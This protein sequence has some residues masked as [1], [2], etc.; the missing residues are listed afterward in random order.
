MLSRVSNEKPENEMR[1]FVSAKF[2][3]K[4]RVRDAYKKLRTAG[5]E[6]T[7]D[8]TEETDLRAQPGKLDEYHAQCAEQD[9]EGVQEADVLVIF[10]HE[11][12]KG[13]YVELGIALGSA[14]PIVCVSRGLD[15]PS[16]I[17]LKVED[18]YHVETIDQ[19]IAAIGRGRRPT[20]V[21]KRAS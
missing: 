18:V 7:W 11:T 6:I 15:L 9:I 1:V 14:I 8:W 19:A 10:P 21:G 17:F 2:E 13:L 12:G 16:C 4:S 20:W 3:D 5:H